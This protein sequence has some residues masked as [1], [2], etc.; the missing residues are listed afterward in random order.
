MSLW[1]R[2][3]FFRTKTIKITLSYPIIYPHR[4]S[5]AVLESE[6]DPHDPKNGRRPDSVLVLI[7]ESFLDRKDPESVSPQ[8]GW[9]S[10]YFTAGGH[11]LPQDLLLW[12]HM[13]TSASCRDKLFSTPHPPPHPTIPSSAQGVFLDVCKGRLLRTSRPFSV[14]KKIII[15]PPPHPKKTPPKKNLSIGRLLGRLAG[16]VQDCVK[17]GRTQGLPKNILGG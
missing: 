15:Y 4:T 2:L 17:T 14:F 1:Q 12:R 5:D 7:K 11:Y 10:V 8:N 6:N 13:S 3:N 9:V 16:Y